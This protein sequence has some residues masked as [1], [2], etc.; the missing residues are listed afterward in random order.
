MPVGRGA[1]GSEARRPGGGPPGRRTDTRQ[2]RRPPARPPTGR[3]P[4]R[5][6]RDHHTAKHRRCFC[7][8]H[9]RKGWH[10]FSLALG[11]TASAAVS[12][13]TLNS[14][15]TLSASKTSAVATGTIVCP[16]GTEA[17]VTVVITQTSGRTETAAQGTTEVTCTGQVQSWSVTSNVVIGSAFKAGPATALFNACDTTCYPT[18]TKGIKLS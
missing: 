1:A 2:P 15:A 3:A 5:G 12:S 7:R 4:S 10:S 14:K 16:S 17:R 18:Q 9:H 8:A 11:G 13:L 6:A